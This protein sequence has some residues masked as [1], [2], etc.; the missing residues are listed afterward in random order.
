MMPRNRGSVAKNSA[1]KEFPQ[2]KWCFAKM[3][4]VQSKHAVSA[5][6]LAR[7]GREMTRTLLPF[8]VFVAGFLVALGI[9]HVGLQI[10]YQRARNRAPIWR[11]LLDAIRAP[12]WL[13]CVAAALDLALRYSDFPQAYI[14]R[15]EKTIVAV[16]I[17]SF[18]LATANLAVRWIT[19]KGEQKEIPFAAAGLART[20]VRAIVFVAGTTILLWHF[21]MWK[22][23]TPLLTALG[24]GG[25]AVA[26]ALQ[27]TLA[28]FFAGIHIIVENPISLGDY[29]KLASGEDGTVTDIGWRTTRL[30]TGANNTVVIPNTKI[31]T[32][33][34]T[35]FH[36]PERRVVSEVVI[37]A[38]LDADPDQIASI[39]LDV[40]AETNGVLREP[41]PTV[42]FDPG[43]TLTHIQMKMFINVSS[44]ANAG[45]VVSEV[46]V[47]I[48]QRFREQGVPLPAPDRR[49]VIQA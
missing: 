6:A 43:V 32:G 2:S 47:G 39:A 46:R 26:L 38:A 49:V 15:A 22:S 23:V 42:L 27:D 34:L 4:N 13:W 45:G 33:I 35:N 20:L 31:T 16:L 18:T 40:A 1:N 29:I 9:R 10:L 24:V 5:A 48:L 37:Y 19:L 7:D 41:A 21:E 44:H 36:V 11:A 8:A 17:I 3:D 14:G 28:N 12:S 30:R 25:L